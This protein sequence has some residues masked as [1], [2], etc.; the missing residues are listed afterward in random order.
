MTQKVTTL[1]KLKDKKVL[2]IDY[3][4]KVIG[5]ACYHVGQDPFPTPYSRIIQ[6]SQ[7]LQELKN[8]V[9]EEEIEVIVFGVPYF[10]D[11]SAGEMTLN[12]L[13]KA[14]EVKCFL[15]DKLDFYTQDETYSTQ[16]AKDRMLNDPFGQGQVDLKKIDQVSA[17]IIIEYFLEKLSWFSVKNFSQ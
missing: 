10:T 6:S 15:P 17:A 3:G 8:I 1:E 16:E 12:L 7:A 4:E 13:K 5:L 9:L 14:E 2:G 11:S